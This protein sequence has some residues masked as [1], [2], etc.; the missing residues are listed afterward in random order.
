ML[1][2]KIYFFNFNKEHKII[3]QLKK[4]FNVIINNKKKF[5]FKM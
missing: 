3:N 2:K 1:Q 5:I 4:T